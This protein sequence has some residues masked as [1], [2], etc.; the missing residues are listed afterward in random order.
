M[1][2]Q[3]TKISSFLSFQIG[4]ETFA[5]S[6]SNVTNI[7]EM[8]KIT[9]V[10]K[11]PPHLK[12]VINLRGSILPVIDTRI[13]FG[14]KEVG[15]S[16]S[17]SILVLEMMVKNEVLRM[18]AIVDGVQEV[19]EISESEIMPPPSIGTSFNAEIIKGMVNRDG[20]FILIIDVKKVLVEDDI[21][22]IQEQGSEIRNA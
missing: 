12:G 13:K 10:P 21:K 22:V 2:A 18:G 4:T 3:D 16:N 15:Y 11:S 7:L 6:V 17:T 14:I 5:T 20:K 8:V 19:L 1:Q 9:R